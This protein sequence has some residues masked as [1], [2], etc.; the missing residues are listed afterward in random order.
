MNFL[1]DTHILLWAASE[2]EKLSVK[3]QALITNAD[4]QLF[5]SPANFWEISIKNHLGRPDF[6]VNSRQL[7]RQLLLN[8]YQELPIVSEHTIAIDS[9]PAIHKDPFDRLLLAQA[10]VE[11]F[12]LL[13]MDNIIIQYGDPVFN[14]D[15][16]SL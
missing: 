11:K 12:H 10:K 4:N 9:L 14:V 16:N 5:F 15:A 1:L 13:T 2:P 8:G 3:M 7:W 6:Q